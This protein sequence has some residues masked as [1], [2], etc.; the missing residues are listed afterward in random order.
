V[1][2]PIVVEHFSRPRNVGRIDDA[3]GVGRVD[4]RA[5]DNL[6]TIYLKLAGTRVAAARFRTLGCSACIAASSVATELVQGRPLAVA[7]RVDA[8]AILA[9]LG[10]L[11]PDKAHCAEL[12]ARALRQAAE[13]AGR[14]AGLTVDP[15]SPSGRGPG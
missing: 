1:Y 5:T 3:D 14:S 6:I 11:P 10:G 7:L 15:P 2:G 9:A 12:A 13:T 8:A 4:D